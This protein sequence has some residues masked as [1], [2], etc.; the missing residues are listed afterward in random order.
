MHEELND[1]V[2]KIKFSRLNQMIKSSDQKDLF[3]KGK[4]FGPFSIRYPINSP[5]HLNLP[6]PLHLLPFFQ[7][8]SNRFLTKAL[9]EK[10]FYET[11]HDENADLSNLRVYDCK[12]YVIDYHAKEK[13]KMT[14]RT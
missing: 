12:T 13:D 9:D 6:L 3:S 1:D 4:F 7:H 10:T 8:L 5:H 2:V 11:W 14:K